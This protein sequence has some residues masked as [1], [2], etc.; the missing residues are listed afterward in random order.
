MDGFLF[1]S[2]K[3][4]ETH[5]PFPNQRK[6]FG[7]QMLMTFKCLFIKSTES[8]TQNILDARGC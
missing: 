8:F 4:S 7:M 1:H 3:L 6:I 2:L 5:L